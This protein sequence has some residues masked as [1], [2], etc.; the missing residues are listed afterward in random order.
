MNKEITTRR[1][2]S[3]DGIRGL[4]VIM[5]VMF[6]YLCHPL[7]LS[8]TASKTWHLVGKAIGFG[9]IGVDLFFVLSGF[10]IGGILLNNR[11]SKNYF[12]TFYIRRSL[13]I[14]P[15]YFLLLITFYLI[16]NF[17]GNTAYY[18]FENPLPFW[19]YLTF[20]QNFLMGLSNHFGAGGLTPTWSLAIEEQFYILCPLLIWFVKPKYIPW[21]LIIVILIGPISRFLVDDW[22][23]AYVWFHCRVDSLSIG[24]LIAWLYKYKYEPINKRKNMLIYLMLFFA[25]L[26]AFSELLFGN[27]GAISHTLIALF[28]GS[29]ILTL[30]YFPQSQVTKIF[31]SRFLVYFGGISYSLYL[32]HNL[33]NCILHQVILQN[34]QPILETKYDV[35]IT[36]SATILSIS[37]TTLLKRFLEDPLIKIG[38]KRSY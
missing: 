8:S 29:L 4:A 12:T 3:L 10:L 26:V 35:M 13:R 7:E 33:I 19:G 17:I 25:T 24:V 27:L 18:T 20:T 9:W 30:L 31:E 16:G 21:I 15:P 37:L 6:H 32:F 2:S 22:H 28:F 11:E 36:I 34:K 23:K 38:K 5:V 1:I 14:L